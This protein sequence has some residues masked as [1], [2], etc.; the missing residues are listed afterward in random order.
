MYI[1]VQDLI[2][3]PIIHFDQTQLI[4]N[5]LNNGEITP[6]EGFNRDCQFRPLWVKS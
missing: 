1:T 4:Q 3:D 5:H 6:F 2:L